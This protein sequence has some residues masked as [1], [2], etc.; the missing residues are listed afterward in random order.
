MKWK[1][2]TYSF[3]LTHFFW[4][5]AFFSKTWQVFALPGA[6]QCATP[7]WL[8]WSHF[9]L[10][11]DL[12]AL[13]NQWEEL[14]WGCGQDCRQW[15]PRQLECMEAACIFCKQEP[16]FWAFYHKTALYIMKRLPWHPAATSTSKDP[17]LLDTW[18]FIF[19]TSQVLVTF[20]WEENILTSKFLQMLLFQ[21]S[22]TLVFHS[23]LPLAV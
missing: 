9:Q 13:L 15:W 2:N 23:F 1:R 12:R 10:E 3:A 6:H 19:P 21:I 11:T 4:L 7:L 16:L 18:N 20:F 5:W 17:I 22:V 14:C 8:H